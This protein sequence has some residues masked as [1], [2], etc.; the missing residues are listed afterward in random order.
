MVYVFISQSVISYNFQT[1]LDFAHYFLNK[2]IDF[3]M[4]L[5]SSRARVHHEN[6]FETIIHLIVKSFSQSMYRLQKFG[7]TEI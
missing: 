3:C 1:T 6:N 2:F 4:S 5:F 7:C